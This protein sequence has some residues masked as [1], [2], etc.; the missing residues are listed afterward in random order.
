MS[1][2]RASAPVRLVRG[3]AAAVIILLAAFIALRLAGRR[4]EAPSSPA[5]PPPE[6]RIVDLKERVRHQEYREGRP[7]ADIRGA[8]FFRGP[9]G[10]N[11]L[12]GGIEVAN[13][14]PA[15]ETVSRLTA[16]EVAYDP[17]SLRFSVS[18]RVRVEAGGVALEGTA[19]DYDK[20]AGVFETQ[21]GGV[22]SS[23]TMTGRAGTVLYAEAAGE[24]RLGGGVHVE[25]AATAPEGTTVVLEGGSFTYRRR[26]RSGRIEDRAV[27]SGGGWRAGARSLAFLATEDESQLESAVLDGEARLVLSGGPSDLPDSAEVR[28]ELIRVLFGGAPGLIVSIGAQGNAVLSLTGRGGPGSLVRAPRAGLTFG[29]EGR[30]LGWSAADG[31]RAELA[32]GGVPSRALEAETAA[33]DALTDAL[34]V[35]GVPGRPASAESAEVRVEAASIRSGP[36]PEALEASGGALCVFKPGEERRAAGLF[37]P[38]EA[39]SVTSDS[40]VFRAG[41]TSASFAGHV[42]AWQGQQSL[43]A[44]ELAFSGAGDMR[45]RGGVTAWLEQDTP[46]DA[47]G[48][49]V[50]LGGSDM[51]FASASRTLTLSGEAHIRLAEARLE[52]GTV[53][54]VL[55]P[56]RSSVET[57]SAAK[58]VAVSKGR[59]LGRAEAASYQAA[60]RRMTLTGK[61]VLTDGKGGSA[62]GAKLTFDLA[63]DKIFI[64]NEGPGRATTVV[65]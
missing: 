60:T 47:A 28:A 7:V 51:D 19:F 9:D 36:G 23:K 45:G 33:F 31:V 21:A 2:Q 62:R 57:L 13:L 1:D 15:G 63:D 59:Y 6:G 8:S 54:A 27:I 16:D 56:D 18:G 12:A 34:I 24:V 30:L 41:E 40:A 14:G 48:R 52:A 5:P 46:G 10:R 39:V 58:A 32:E 44:G 11:H 26:E 42:R 22:F 37:P 20:S 17:G 4:G 53:S 25:L 65:R 55:S 43:L 3:A 29:S 49:R 50:E 35:R 64:E 38:G 61:P